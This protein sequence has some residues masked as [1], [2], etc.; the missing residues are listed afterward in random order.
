M[1]DQ[2]AR[3]TISVVGCVAAFYCKVFA[4]QQAHPEAAKDILRRERYWLKKHHL[5]KRG[6]SIYIDSRGDSMFSVHLN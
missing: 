6:C 3:S 2:Q 1:M 4:L 5:D